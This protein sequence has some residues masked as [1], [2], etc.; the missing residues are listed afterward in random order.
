MSYIQFPGQR[1]CLVQLILALS[2]V[3]YPSGAN[4]SFSS[5]VAMA[6]RE[7]L[8]A[9]VHNG[10]PQSALVYEFNEAIHFSS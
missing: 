5:V 1:V 8:E 3:K 10:T 6:T 4:L 2:A 7:E 9:N